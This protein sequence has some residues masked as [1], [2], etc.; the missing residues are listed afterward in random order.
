MKPTV[1]M[2]D[3]DEREADESVLSAETS[4]SSG[5]FYFFFR[6]M[7]ANFVHNYHLF[8]LKD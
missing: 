5:K 4:S 7:Q 8:Y 1:K 3:E 2:T 6:Q